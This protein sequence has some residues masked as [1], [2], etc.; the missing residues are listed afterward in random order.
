MV[1]MAVT[2]YDRMHHP[3]RTAVGLASTDLTVDDTTTCGNE[4]NSYNWRRF[5]LF[6]SLTETGTLVNGDRVRIT[7]Q[8]REVGGTWCDYYNGPFGALYEEESTTPCDVCVSG[9]CMAE[10]MRICVTTDYT[11]ANPAANHFV[12]SSYITLVR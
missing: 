8:F 7:V 12:L 6:Y 9:D 2:R 3:K 1:K 5:L 4:I 11:N 10:R